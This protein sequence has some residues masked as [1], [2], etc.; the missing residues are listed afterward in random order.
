MRLRKEGVTERVTDG[1][2]SL[3]SRGSDPVFHMLGPWDP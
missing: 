2:S 1:Q 3:K